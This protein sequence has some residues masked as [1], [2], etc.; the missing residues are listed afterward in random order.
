MVS[1]TI[2][3]SPCYTLF[4]AIR[5]R[6]YSNVDQNLKK[7][8]PRIYIKL[9][10]KSTV[11]ENLYGFNAY[12]S[13]HPDGTAHAGAA[14]YIKSNITHRSISPYSIPHIQAVSVSLVL[15]NNIPVT[16]SAVYC[17]TG[18]TIT[19]DI[20]S[21]YFSIKGHRFISGGD[22][23][24]KNPARD[25]CSLSTRGRALKQC[26]NIK[27]DSSMVLPGPSYCPSYNNRF[28][29]ILDIYVKKLPRNI[30]S[31]LINLYDLFSDH[32]PTLLRLG[33]NVLPQQ[34]TSEERPQVN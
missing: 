33:L 18:L 6:F 31:N 32:I 27:N 14:I 26:I 12:F 28:P 25:N 22:F 30:H 3:I 21:N 34:S 16:V 20:F 23:N 19:S 10:C 7:I 8:N 24:S 5:N 1:V 17:L 29:D 4:S 15:P 11:S 9:S 13:Y 2:Q